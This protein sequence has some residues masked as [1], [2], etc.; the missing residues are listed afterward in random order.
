MASVIVIPPAYDSHRPRFE[1]KATNSWVAPAESVRIS[2]DQ[3]H[4]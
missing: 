2:V 4:R 1:S 3:P